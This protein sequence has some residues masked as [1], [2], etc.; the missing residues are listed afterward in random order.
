MHWQQQE[1]QNYSSLLG[2]LHTYTMANYLYDSMCRHIHTSW[3]LFCLLCKALS[4]LWLHTHVSLHWDNI[5]SVLKWIQYIAYLIIF[6]TC[7][8]FISFAYIWS[9]SFLGICSLVLLL[10]VIFYVL[11][12]CCDI[13]W[14]NSISIIHM[15]CIKMYYLSLWYT[16]WMHVIVQILWSFMKFWSIETYL[17]LLSWHCSQT[18]IHMVV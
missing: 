1:C 11:H 2:I 18:H 3:I 15:T 14:Q 12:F 5:I 17:F 7:M 13:F 10:L 4:S 8:Y 6:S 16:L 9:L